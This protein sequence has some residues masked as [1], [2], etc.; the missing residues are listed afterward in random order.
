MHTLTL[1]HGE[2]LDASVLL[3]RSGDESDVMIDRLQ[4]GLVDCLDARAT[5]SQG[6]FLVY[7]V[8]ANNLRGD[9]CLSPSLTLSLSSQE[10]NAKGEVAFAWSSDYPLSEPDLQCQALPLGT[11]YPQGEDFSLGP[12]WTIDSRFAPVPNGEG[13][14][15]H[16]LESEAATAT[17]KISRPGRYA[18]WVLSYRR[19]RGGWP[20]YINIDD[21]ELPFEDQSAPLRAWNWNYTGVVEADDE[22]RIRLHRPYGG[23]PRE[24]S[25]LFI[26]GVLLTNDLGFDPSQDT[27]WDA[28]EGIPVPS[29]NSLQRSFRHRFEPGTYRCRMASATGT[30][31]VDQWGRPGASS[32]AVPFH[33]AQ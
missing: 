2:S 33:I 25:A 11:Y 6:P 17:R 1:E 23:P 10:S 9:S 28:L 32:S 19:H 27:I 21:Q 16:N 24:F 12:G 30:V 22:V 31:L 7:Q 3:F 4:R 14:L 13:F 26:D 8:G 15:S 18:V 20:G 5:Y 29:E